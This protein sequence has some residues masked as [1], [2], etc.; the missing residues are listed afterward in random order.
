MR[1]PKPKPEEQAHRG[2]PSSSGANPNPGSGIVDLYLH[3]APLSVAQGRTPSELI[4]GI[5]QGLPVSE[6]T[7][8]QAVLDMPIERLAPKLGISR[9]T[10]NRRLAKGRLEPL[11][12]DRLVR[13]ARLMG[14]ATEVLETK[15]NARRWLGSPQ[16]GLGGAVPLD[17]A[18]TEVGAREV[19][20]LL[21]RIEYG[22]YS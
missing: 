10:L 8:L 18:E 15:E 12:S 6:L 4:E 13:F 21:G 5:R 2:R 20:D 9:A 16:I 14:K 19:E 7:A 3:E 22:V 1:K 11:E 17:Y